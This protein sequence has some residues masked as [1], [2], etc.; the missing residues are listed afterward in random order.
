M[1]DISTVGIH[2]EDK[3]SYI[4]INS[5][6]I[7]FI[8]GGK[9]S[10][11]INQGGICINNPSSEYYMAMHPNG[12]TFNGRT[13]NDIPTAMGGFIDIRDYMT[14]NNFSVAIGEYLS[15]DEFAS[16]TDTIS[17]ALAAK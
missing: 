4:T 14:K 12:L 16:Y 6:T 5:G 2:C 10:L 3:N 11:L 9:Q 15:K 13:Q 7:D 8:S 1:F 17:A